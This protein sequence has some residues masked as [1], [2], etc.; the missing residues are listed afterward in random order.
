MK[1]T[2]RTQ[3]ISQRTQRISQRTQRIS[4][5]TQRISQRTQRISQRDTES[6]TEDTEGSQSKNAPLYRREFCDNHCATK[7]LGEGV[8]VIFSCTG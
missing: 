4:Q 1:F 3:I 8:I 7:S 6:F 5:R 2:T